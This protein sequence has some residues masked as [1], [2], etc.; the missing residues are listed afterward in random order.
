MRDAGWRKV[1]QW[2]LAGPAI[3]II[4]LLLLLGYPLWLVGVGAL[5]LASVVIYFGVRFGFRASSSEIAHAVDEEGL[6]KRNLEE[7]EKDIL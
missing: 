5:Y 1:I 7:V 2:V 3:L 4:W 6:E